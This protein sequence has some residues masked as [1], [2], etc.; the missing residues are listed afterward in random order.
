METFFSQTA[1]Y[2]L[3]AMSWIA[4]RPASATVRAV[5]LA[6][7]TDIPAPYL[8]KILRRLVL[9]GVLVS[10]KGH[11]G[12]FELARPP[13]EICF[14]DVLRALDAYPTPDRCAFGWEACDAKSPCPL[15]PHWEPLAVAVREWA[16]ATTF[17]G[18]RVPA[19][20]RSVASGR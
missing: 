9:A 14:A 16:S 6:S 17:G 7:H 1:E 11:G 8:A 20:R 2:A 15:H 13:E 18:L 12:G 19:A 10:H 5:D 4:A 3:R